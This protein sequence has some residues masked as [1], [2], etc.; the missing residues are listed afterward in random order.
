MCVNCKGKE[1][2]TK[3]LLG[4]IWVSFFLTHPVYRPPGGHLEFRGENNFDERGP[5]SNMISMAI[6][7]NHAT[8]Y[9]CTQICTS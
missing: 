7:Y 4:F 5:R 6:N 3:K 8:L 9:A 1:Q 2:R